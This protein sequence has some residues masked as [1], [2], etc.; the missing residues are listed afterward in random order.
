MRSRRDGVP[1]DLARNKIVADGV[2]DTEALFR[3]YSWTAGPKPGHSTFASR[4]MLA[5]LRAQLCASAAPLLERGGALPDET[6]ALGPVW[7]ERWSDLASEDR[8]AS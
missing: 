3:D 1:P 4:D 2:E 6:F 8:G 7:L 5:R